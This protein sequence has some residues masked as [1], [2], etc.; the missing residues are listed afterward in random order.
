V[1]RRGPFA[2]VAF[3]VLALNGKDVRKVPLVERKRLLRAIVPKGSASITYASHVAE[4]G[5]DLFAE[6]CA[7]K[8]ADRLRR[9]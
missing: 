9:R 4:R 8:N 1:R 2:Y 6:V 7:Q 5:R 3:D